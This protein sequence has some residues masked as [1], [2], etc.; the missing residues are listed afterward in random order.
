MNRLGAAL[1]GEVSDPPIMALYVFGANPAGVSP[2]AGKIVEGLKREDLFT[3]VHELFMTDTA[4]YADIVLPAT[5]QLEHVDL[6]KGYGHTIL[7]Y[8]HPAISPLGESKSNWEVMSLLA[9]ALGLTDPW[10]HQTP[11]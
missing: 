1:L 7:T 2:N 10:L 11:D 4:D 3:V 5:S 8:N 9:K 6:H